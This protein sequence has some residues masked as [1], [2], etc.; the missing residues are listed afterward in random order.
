AW[1]SAVISLFCQSGG[2]VPGKVGITMFRV[3]AELARMKNPR[4]LN[5]LEVY[6]V[7]G[8]P[9]EHACS[10]YGVDGSYFSRQLMA[11]NRVWKLTEILR[12]DQ[13]MIASA[14]ETQEEKHDSLPD[15]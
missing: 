11:L 7:Q 2:L 1:L 10:M 13:G 5:A 9:R 12:M 15:S 14:G 6:L 4:I 3:L 8:L